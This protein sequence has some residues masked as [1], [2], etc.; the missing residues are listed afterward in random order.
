MKGAKLS[1][2][3]GTSL[4]DIQFSNTSNYIKLTRRPENID[5]CTTDDVRDDFVRPPHMQLMPATE[6]IN[7]CR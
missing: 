7:K 3:P 2:P 4:S 6:N 5:N 1:T